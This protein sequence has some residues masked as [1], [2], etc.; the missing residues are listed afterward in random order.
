MFSEEQ[1]NVNIRQNSIEFTSYHDLTFPIM[2]KKKSK[3]TNH[4][5]L[6]S[7]QPGNWQIVLFFASSRLLLLFSC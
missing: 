2:L 6:K 1:S 7:N 4:L 5:L 3:E